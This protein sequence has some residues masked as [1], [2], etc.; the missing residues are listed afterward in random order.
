[1][2]HSKNISSKKIRQKLVGSLWEYWKGSKMQLLKTQYN[3][4]LRTAKEFA[5]WN[6]VLKTPV[7]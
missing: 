5:D 4:H 2:N 1:M 3:I 6:I 7:V